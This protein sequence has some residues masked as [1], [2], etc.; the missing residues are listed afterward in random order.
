VLED[1]PGDYNHANESEKVH[2]EPHA[3]FL[4]QDSLLET[5]GIP[6]TFGEK[7]R[8][9]LGRWGEIDSGRKKQVAGSRAQVW[10]DSL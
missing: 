6:Q 9:S 5:Q 3:S 8:E 2:G 7:G 10:A 4:Q 1:D